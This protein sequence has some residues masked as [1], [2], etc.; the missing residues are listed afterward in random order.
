MHVVVVGG[1][2]AGTV[3]AIALRQIG[4]EV[5]MVEAYPDP[6]G[7][8]GSFLS[9][10][11]NGLRA[12]DAIGCRERVSARGFPVARQRVW[13]G[14]GAL[15]GD[16]PRGRLASDPLTSVTLMRADL[17]DELRQAAAD[18]GVDIV[19]GERLA[20]ASRQADSVRVQLA[21]GATITADLLVGADGIWSTTR[22]LLDPTAPEPAYAGLYTISGFA[23][24]A[25]VATDES[26]FNMVMARGGAFI[27]LRHPDGRIWWQAQVTSKQEPARE[28]VTDAEW[29]RVL[30]D[31]FRS[32]RVPS[33]IIAATTQ[34]H[35]PTLNHVV[36]PVPA[37]HDDRIVI[38]GDAAHPVG[39]GQGASMAIESGRALAAALAGAPSVPAALAE[40]D[41]QRRPRVARL[42]AVADGNRKAK[43]AGPLRRAV[44]RVAMPVFFRFFYEK[45][46]AWLYEPVETPRNAK[47]SVARNTGSG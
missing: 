22:R 6:A 3:S 9:I 4:A 30:G 28:G 40:F 5:T 26:V 24:S 44:E 8:I 13:S 43:K 41:R 21:G 19:L 32:E 20:T 37:W 15:L 14:S 39:A 27:H 23:E 36:G 18:N 7:T 46:T 16:A 35:R 33:A 25:D 1:G 2:V 47:C 17:V 42:L 12:L 29:L 34:L 10:A 45:A 11:T 31:T 38:V